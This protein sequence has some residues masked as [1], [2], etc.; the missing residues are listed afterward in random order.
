VSITATTSNPGVRIGAPIR[1]VALQPFSSANLTIP[2]TLLPSAPRNTVITINLHVAGEDTCDKTG[3]DATLSIL[4]GADDIPA[5][6]TIDHADTR[7]SPWTSTGAFAADVW[8]HARDASGN[9]FFFGKDAGFPTDTQ[10]VSPPLP[11]STTQPFVVRFQHAYSLEASGGTLFDGGMIEISLNGGATWNDVTAFGINPGYTGLLTSGTDNPL[12]GRAAFSG[13][14]PG[15]PAR[16][17]VVLNFGKI[18]AGLSVQLRFRIGTD[19]AVALT[20]WDIDDVQVDGITTTPFPLLVAEPSTCTA[21]ERPIDEG[22]VVAIH[23]APAAS[24]RSFDAA[25][26]IASDTP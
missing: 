5:A 14:S 6:S 10:F 15:F 8:G 20:G 24:L 21:R 17:P 23:A 16:T 7:I 19:A 9:P 13:T 1:L 12:A 11:V 25:V 3:V 18:P 4:T 2:V 22:S 26:C